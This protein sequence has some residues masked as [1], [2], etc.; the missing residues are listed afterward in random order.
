[1]LM[2]ARVNNCHKG[3]PPLNF[4]GYS[5]NF[6]EQSPSKILN[7]RNGVHTAP[8][9]SPGDEPGSELDSSP[10]LMFRTTTPRTSPGSRGYFLGYPEGLLPPWLK[11][12]L[13]KVHHRAPEMW[14]LLHPV[15]RSKPATRSAAGVLFSLSFP[16]TCL[17]PSTA[18]AVQIKCLVRVLYPAWITGE[19]E[20]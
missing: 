4:L 20:A 3:N 13:C 16:P 8:N 11:T 19:G 18:L 9:P 12:L 15:H 17:T 6:P 14:A 10:G 2:R 7:A 5:L 1:M